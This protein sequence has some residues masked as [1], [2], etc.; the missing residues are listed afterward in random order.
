MN[1]DGRD[2]L[3]RQS[4]LEALDDIADPR[5]GDFVVFSNGLIRRISHLWDDAIQ[6]SDQGSWYLGE[7]Y[8]SFSG[9][10]FGITMNDKL[11][12]LDGHQWDAPVWFF[13]H[14]H[15]QAHNAIHTTIPFR[16]YTV[17]EEAPR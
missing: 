13:H 14:N 7:G 9:S 4:R 17:D 11:I 2:Q 3:I 15:A 6:T 8:V 10:L 5:V 16:V 12:K 1:L